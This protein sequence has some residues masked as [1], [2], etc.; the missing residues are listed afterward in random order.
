[1][2]ALSLVQHFHSSCSLAI[3]REP[4]HQNLL[5]FEADQKPFDSVYGAFCVTVSLEH[6]SPE[7]ELSEA[8][9]MAH[10]AE[11]AAIQHVIWSTRKSSLH[12][13]GTAKKRSF[14]RL[15]CWVESY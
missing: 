15:Q 2:A 5:R 6:F 14:G 8:V 1:M 7:K 13:V 10:A 9:N 3:K 4:V 11:C 12:T